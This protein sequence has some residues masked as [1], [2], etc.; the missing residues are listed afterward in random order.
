MTNG[1]SK[2][3]LETG[4]GLSRGFHNLIHGEFKTW[5][6]TRMWWVQILIWTASINLVFLMVALTGPKDAGKEAIMIFCIFL[7]LAGPIGTSIMMQGEVVGEK[8]SGTAAWILSK[9]VSRFSFITSKLVGNSVGLVVTMILAQGLIAYV[10][11][12]LRF[13]LALPLPGF[14]AGLGV[15]FLNI[16]FYLTLTLMLGTLFD[17]PA[18]VIGIPMA[19]LFTQNFLAT[20][21]AAK[22]PLLANCLPW[23]LTMPLN[24]SNALPVAQALMVGEPVVTYLPVFSTLAF[25]II[26]ILIALWRFERQEL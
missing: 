9:P 18:P 24:N 6:G 26:F 15:A 14:L 22:A 7:G 3:I 2:M 20:Y 23:T 4:T 1:N 8:R 21:L 19:F 12:L 17:H 11:T 16:F 25:S 13:Q 5:F 10:V